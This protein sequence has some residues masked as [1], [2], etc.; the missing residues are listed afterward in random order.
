MEKEL[1]ELLASDPSQAI[2]KIEALTKNNAEILKYRKEYF[3]KDRS[4]RPLQLDKIQ[5]DKPVKEKLVRAV[6]IPVN[7]AKKIVTT[8][9]SFEV[10]KPVT[11]TPSE[12]N[13]DLSKVIKSLWKSNR[14]DAMVTKLVELKK[15]ETQGAVQFYIVDINESSNFK[16]VL[17]FFK[18]SSPKKEIKS[19]LLNNVS[20]VMTPYFDVDGDMIL[21]MWQYQTKN[22]DDKSVNN[23]EIW[24]KKDKHHFTDESGSFVLKS[25]LQHGFDR[26]PI[27][28]VS[29]DEPEWFVVKEMIDR[30]EVTLSKLG[31]SNDY[32][33]HPLLKIFG[34][35][36][37]MPQRDDSGKILR[38][39]I[40]PDPN[41]P[42]KFL[43]HGN[44]EFAV[45]A[46]AVESQKL[47]IES[48]LNL[49]HYI[50][51]TPN[52]SFDNLKGLGAMSGTAIRLVFLDAILKSVLNE[53]ENRTMIERM[54]N[55]LVSGVVNVTNTAL[56]KEAELLYFDIEFNS[57]L[58]DDVKEAVDMVNSAVTSGTMSKKT[59]IEILA[60]KDDVEQEMKDI[61]QDN[62]NK[63]SNNIQ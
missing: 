30:I 8:A 25:K 45:A 46:N 63:Q 60:F 16:K 58:P 22:I 14:L 61:E 20:G 29:Q 17:N 53:P 39:P 49:I 33:A 10:G 44:A 56:K 7:F 38:F 15:R 52:I 28:Y 34:E 11:I 37:D 57:I 43:P 12:S 31:A 6:K 3:E 59:A 27:V 21:F 48:L 4:Q 51:S 62:K 32:S 5:E 41:D 2:K 42:T 18:L 23:V 35:I 1:L 47:E 9:T 55:I 13:S 36:A 50:S 54:L 26:I 19:K 40:N 24:D